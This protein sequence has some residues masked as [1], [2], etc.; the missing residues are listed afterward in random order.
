MKEKTIHHIPV[1][2]LATNCWIYPLDKSSHREGSLP[3]HPCIVIDPGDEADQIIALLDK[4]NY[5]PAYILLTHGH[6]DHIGAGPFLAAH[7]GRGTSREEGPKIAVHAADREFLGPDY[8]VDFCLAEGDSIGPFSVLHL[9]GHS[10]GSVGLWDKSAEVLFS[11]DT[12]FCDGYGRTDL[13]GGSEAQL[14]ASL[15]RLF[16]MD[17]NIQV[18][19]GH[20][21]STSIKIEAVRGIIP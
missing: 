2:F 6:F 13:P 7:Y 1:G 9:P 16:A 3:A 19:P 17:G 12:L 4:L 18:Y 20:G 10:P 15:K 21:P 14:F 5:F 11:G 8:P